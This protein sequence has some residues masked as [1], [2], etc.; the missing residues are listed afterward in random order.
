[1]PLGNNL[2]R[3]RKEKG[4]KQDELAEQ[5]GVSLTQISKIERNETDP[6]ISTIEK[7]SKALECSADRL[8]FDKESHGLSGVV[9]EAVG[10]I[11]RLHPQDKVLLIKVIERFCMGTNVL[12][13]AANFTMDEQARMHGSDMYREKMPILHRA[14][15]ED[16]E[17]SQELGYLDE[18]AK[19]EE[20]ELWMKAENLEE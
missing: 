8:I 6:R 5:A 3:L 20:K 9:K 11:D 12:V 2:Q 18:M 19:K 13:E 7:I 4:L 14:Y 15:E 10:K 17:R 1:M 16:Q